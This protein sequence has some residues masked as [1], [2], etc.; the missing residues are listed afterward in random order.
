MASL[1]FRVVARWYEIG[2]LLGV[3]VRILNDILSDTTLD[4]KERLREVLKSWLD[5]MNFKGEKSWRV[6]ADAVD[7]PAGGDNPAEAMKIAEN[8][9]TI[10]GM[11]I[12]VP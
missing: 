2:V 9:P 6:L 8:H 5:R 11:R 4:Q 12:L 7:H 3:K 10:N 1:L